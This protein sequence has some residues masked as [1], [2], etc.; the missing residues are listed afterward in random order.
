MR[1]YILNRIMVLVPVLFVVS[2]AVFSLVHLIPGDPI[3]YMLSQ[4]ELANP[5]MRAEMEKN[6]GL[7]KP[8][9]LQ[10][11]D[12]IGK[13]LRGDFGSPSIMGGLILI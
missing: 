5:E 11:A 4:S 12:W 6:L 2:L 13:I 9:Y 1:K 8:L 7:D 3:D 10:Y